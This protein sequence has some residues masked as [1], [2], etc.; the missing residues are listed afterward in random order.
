MSA[1]PRTSP[2]RPAVDVVRVVYDEFLRGG[3]DLLLER[4]DELFSPDFHFHPALIGGL[5]RNR[6]YV[7]LDEFAEYWR[8]FR[9]VFSDPE[10]GQAEFEP[11]GSERA[12]ATSHI[13]AKGAAS[14]A[15]FEQEA[16]YLFRV[17]DGLIAEMRTFFSRDEALAFAGILE[18][19]L[20][21]IADLTVFFDAMERGDREV[22]LEMVERRC[23]PDCEIT[24][25][26]SG[27]I[28]GTARG[29]EEIKELF[30]TILEVWSVRYSHQEFRS[31]RTDALVLRH[32]QSVKGR[33]S[34]VE[35]NVTGGVIWWLDGD[36]A[37]RAETYVD[38]GDLER[39]VAA[40][41]AGDA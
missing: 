20:P 17:R 1:K 35:F 6:E 28:D 23:H 27:P 2:V 21:V 13:R 10:F 30:A 31:A 26:V 34:E 29:H 38:P 36:R 41:E 33:G 18:A 14:G 11:L 3:P 16:A 4:Y 12:I 19:H 24:S 22:V 39:A 25:A 37:R 7:G 15:P 5:E 9:S 32:H 8:E 40:I